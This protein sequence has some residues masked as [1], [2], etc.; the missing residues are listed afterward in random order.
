MNWALLRQQA[1]WSNFP[2]SLLF[3]PLHTYTVAI[4]SHLFFLLMFVHAETLYHIYLISLGVLGQW[5]P[6]WSS[7][8]PQGVMSWIHSPALRGY[9][10][11]PH[12][13]RMLIVKK[14]LRKL[15]KD[16][17]CLFLGSNTQLAK[18]DTAWSHTIHAFVASRWCYQRMGSN[19]EL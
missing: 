13:W 7:A 9:R 1:I 17:C 4:I 10:C 6:T 18:Y 5:F 15:K 3:F 16:F 12:K 14:T 2:A 11:R 19:S 8:V